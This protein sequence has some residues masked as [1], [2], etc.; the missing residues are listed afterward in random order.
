MHGTKKNKG[1]VN[2]PV[3]RSMGHENTGHETQTWKMWHD[4]TRRKHSVKAD[5]QTMGH[6]MTNSQET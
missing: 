1:C 5:K 2:R 4:K 3:T 6:N